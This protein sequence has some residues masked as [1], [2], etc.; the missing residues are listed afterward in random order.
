MNSSRFVKFL[1]DNDMSFSAVL[2][3]T[4]LV[5]LGRYK[6]ITIFIPHDSVY[7]I[8]ANAFNTSIDILLQHP[9]LQ[10]MIAN[11]IVPNEIISFEKHNCFS[12]INGSTI[13]TKILPGLNLVNLIDY[14]SKEQPVDVEITKKFDEFDPIFLWQ[15]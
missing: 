11:H 2:L 12:S 1:S 3:K 5:T 8:M 13:C 7:A 9:Q 15:K 6:E 4:Y 14:D 10:K